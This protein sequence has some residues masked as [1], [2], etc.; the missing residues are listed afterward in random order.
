[1]KKILSAVLFMTALIFPSCLDEHEDPVDLSL[2][3][4]NIYC[5]DGNIYP[6]DI[7]LMQD[8]PAAGV[9]TAIGGTDDGYR[10]LVVAL[11]DIG[12]TYYYN[13]TDEDVSGVS[14]D[15]TTIDGKENTA[16]LVYA[17]VEDSTAHPSAA[18]LCTSYMASGM[19]AWHVPSVAEFR[20]VAE[21][22]ATVARS[23]SAV[24]AQPLGD[25]Y[26]TS[27]VDG[28]GQNNSQLYNYLI[29]LPKG[30]VSSA[31]KTE[32]HY[33]RPFLILK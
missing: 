1:M 29:E 28:S 25:C 32:S 26:Q 12:R 19:S 3:V 15:L 8:V 31:V 33:V 17:A 22:F 27:T 4:G 18:L 24:K 23:L 2:K 16:A 6:V 20:T 5:E 13:K 9:V 30:N 10:A 21:N 7:Y 11:E 14:S